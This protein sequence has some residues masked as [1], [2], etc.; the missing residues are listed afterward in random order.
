MK[1]AFVTVI[2]MNSLQILLNNVGFPNNRMT[3]YSSLPL[4]HELSIIPLIY[5]GSTI[6]G[7]YKLLGKQ[8]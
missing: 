3:E 4:V 5:H 8:K 7:G 2:F 6:E 1:D